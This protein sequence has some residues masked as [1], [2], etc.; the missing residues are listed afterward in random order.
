GIGVPEAERKFL[1][2]A[3]SRATNIGDKPG[4]GLG[5]FIAQKCAQANGA[6]LRYAPQPVGSLFSVTIPFAIADTNPVI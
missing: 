5:L 4:S 6:V 1:F 2:D 3:F